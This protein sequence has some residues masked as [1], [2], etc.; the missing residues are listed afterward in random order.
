[1][2]KYSLSCDVCK[3]KESFHDLH[4]IK[5]MHWHILAWDVGSGLPLVTCSDCEYKINKITKKDYND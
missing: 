1:M 5:T 3:K 2:A 4:D